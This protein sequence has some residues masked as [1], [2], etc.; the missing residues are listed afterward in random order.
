MLDTFL[1]VQ[2]KHTPIS[3][4]FFLYLLLYEECRED[5]NKI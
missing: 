1:P 3:V 5:A 2:K 4:F